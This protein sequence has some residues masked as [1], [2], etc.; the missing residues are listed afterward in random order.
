MAQA[1]SSELRAARQAAS[2]RLPDADGVFARATGEN[3]SVASALLGRETERHLTAIYGYARLVDQIGDASPGD[4]LALLDLLEAEIAGIYDGASIPT[5][6]VLARL[7]PTINDLRLP[8]GPFQRLIEA[9]RLDQRKLDYETFDELV[10][11]CN[12]SA[13]P[14]GELVLHVLGAAT[15]E[16]IA[17]SD[18][19]CTALQLVEHWQDVAEDRAAGRIY[20]PADDRA[21]FEVTP[22]DLDGNVTPQ[23]VRNLLAFEVAR[24]RELL[25]EG[26]L[27][28]G[29]LHGRARIAVAGY[30]GGGRAALD[31]I[32][33]S[34]YD[35]LAG[36]PRAGRGRR[37]RATLVTFVRRGRA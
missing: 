34:G 30:V 12:L 3:F 33:A 5:H 20:L 22:A 15:P 29:M 25:D 6:P 27:L 36:P 21:R 37:A 28:V 9:N 16:R 18:K 2:E 1:A 7:A 24:A 13:D 31:A 10:A 8:P 14:V 11:Y 32:A 26:A 19:V 17:L 35:V 4:R 23:Q